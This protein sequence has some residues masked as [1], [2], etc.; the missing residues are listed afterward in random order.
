M[1]F[2]KV[3]Y[4]EAG[5]ANAK[6]EFEP[7]AEGTY[8]AMFTEAKVGKSSAGNDMITVTLTIRDDVKQQFAKRKVWDYL[9]YSEKA[10]WK[11]QQVSK[12]LVI[13]EGH[14]FANIQEFA[15][16]ILHSCVKITIKQKTEEYN[17]ETKTREQI[18]TYSPTDFKSNVQTTD[19]FQ[20]KPNTSSSDFPI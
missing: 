20:V 2:L 11:L 6:K 19:P 16:A 10:K 13:P 3:N 9:V 5:N 4:A 14:E 18:S 12:A 7:I 15:K 8:E 1:S 17:G